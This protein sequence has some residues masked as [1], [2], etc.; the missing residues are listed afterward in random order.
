MFA[1]FDDD[2]TAK[3]NET[4][5]AAPGQVQFDD[6]GN[7]VYSWRDDVL[8]RDGN[9][10]ERLQESALRNSKLSLVEDDTAPTATSTWNAGGLQRGYNPYESGLLAGKKP[11]AKRTDMRELSKWIEMKRR[12]GQSPEALAKK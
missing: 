7:A 9:S 8:A 2:T 5:S 1:F 3:S 4:R 11:I 12:M 10:A 6:R